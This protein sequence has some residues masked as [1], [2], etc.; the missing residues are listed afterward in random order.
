[1]ERLAPNDTRRQRLFYLKVRKFQSPT[2]NVLASLRVK[3]TWLGRA[4]QGPQLTARDSHHTQQWFSTAGEVCAQGAFG[5]VWKDW[6][7]ATEAAPSPTKR[8]T[9]PH[10]KEGSSP[11]CQ[12]RCGVKPGSA[13]GRLSA[14]V[15]G[16]RGP[17]RDKK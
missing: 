4:W 12:C 15:R 6:L 8:G 11:K 14:Q 10:H 17:L 3:A 2:T 9:A 16:S 7:E 5:K 1:M 13:A